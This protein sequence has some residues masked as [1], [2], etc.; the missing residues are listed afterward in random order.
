MF[1]LEMPNMQY[2]IT[3]DV[4]EFQ[5]ILANKTKGTSVK[6]TLVSTFHLSPSQTVGRSRTGRVGFIARSSAQ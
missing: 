1:E 2:K 3:L 6:W 5:N 4:F